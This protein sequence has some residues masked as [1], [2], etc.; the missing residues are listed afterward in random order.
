ML[1]VV[2]IS[3]RVWR[4]VD[5]AGNVRDRILL[6]KTDVENRRRSLRQKVHQLSRG[7]FHPRLVGLEQAGVSDI[8]N[9]TLRLNG[10]ED[11]KEDSQ[12]GSEDQSA[13]R[14]LLW[15]R[16]HVSSSGSC[17]LAILPSCCNVSGVICG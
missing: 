6:G 11:N 8:W 17:R 7:D 1:H 15:N 16:I 4:Y 9:G 2:G 3:G 5:G 13:V 14:G 12:H 10:T